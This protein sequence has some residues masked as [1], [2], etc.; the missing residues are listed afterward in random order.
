[1]SEKERLEKEVE[2]LKY[3]LKRLNIALAL[4]KLKDDCIIK[5]KKSE[6][7]KVLTSLELCDMAYS[8]TYERRR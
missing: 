1:M 7:V 5:E 2:R 4:G 3:E 8:N 6:L